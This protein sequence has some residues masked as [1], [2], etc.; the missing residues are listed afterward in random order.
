MHAFKAPFFLMRETRK[1]KQGERERE[2]ERGRSLV[3]I[4]G[5]ERERV[6]AGPSGRGTRT[7]RLV[8][9]RRIVSLS[10]TYYYYYYTFLL[11]LIVRDDVDGGVGDDFQNARRRQ[12]S[13]PH[14]PWHWPVPARTRTTS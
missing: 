10:T 4:N 5:P 9:R 13:S 1:K 14:G 3:L 7:K 2:R 11:Y 8:V 12:R 6:A